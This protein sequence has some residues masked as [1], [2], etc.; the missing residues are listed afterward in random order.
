MRIPGEY[1]AYDVNGNPIVNTDATECPLPVVAHDCLIY[2]VLADRAMQMMDPNGM[3]IF[4]AQ[5]HGS[6]WA[7][8]II[9]SNVYEED[10]LMAL[11]F[12]ALRTETLR[13]LNETNTS[14]VAELASGVG[15]AAEALSDVALLNYLNEGALEMSRTCT[16][17]EGNI[18]V[19]STTS[20]FK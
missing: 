3:Q 10:S 4:K 1:W 12:T 17:I 18:T 5:I 14:V 11:G 16:L 2:G 20:R 7:S 15:G 19:S 9:C 13:L 8:R 6:P